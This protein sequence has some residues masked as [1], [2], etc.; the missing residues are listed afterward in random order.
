MNTTRL[1]MMTILR[2]VPGSGKTTFAMELLSASP[3]DVVRVSRDD[4]RIALFGK[5][6][7]L[8]HW[9]ETAVTN[10][11]EAAA[12]MA[13]STGK[14]VVIDNTNLRAKYIKDWYK[15]AESVE[16]LDVEVVEFPV[17]YSEMM[18]RNAVRPEK[19]RVPEQVL[20]GMWDKFIDRKTGELRPVESYDKWKSKRS[21]EVS[22][23]PYSP[24]EGL[25]ETFLCD[26]DGTLASADHRDVYDY[27]LVST[28]MPNESTVT[29]VN[30]LLDS[31]HN[32]VFMSGRED[33]CYH[34]TMKWLQKHLKFPEGISPLLYMRKERDNRPDV[35]VKVELFNTFIRGQFNMIGVFDDRPSVCRMWRDMGLKVLQVGDP[36]IEF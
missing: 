6:G 35:I 22:L 16:V 20:D 14:H 15:V 33:V 32:V 21:A 26:L 27:S 3:K 18:D 7:M 5:K 11:C 13:L 25:P 23:S 1:P 34:D 8:D 24:T 29:V 2:G 9:K 12:R 19:D 30:S 28:D 10:V 4:T 31:G 36:H 17:S